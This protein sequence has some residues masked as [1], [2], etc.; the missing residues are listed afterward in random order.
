MDDDDAPGVPVAVLARSSAGPRRGLAK[1]TWTGWENVGKHKADVYAARA[2]RMFKMLQLDVVTRWGS[3]LIM[4]TSF[5]QLAPALFLVMQEQQHLFA[6]YDAPLP[7]EEDF[8]H[9]KAV[10]SVLQP[11]EAAT[12]LLG[13]ESYSTLALVPDTIDQLLYILKQD[14]DD[15]AAYSAPLRKLLRDAYEFKFEP[16]FKEPNLALMAAYTHPQTV[17]RLLTRGYVSGDVITRLEQLMVT[18]MVQLAMPPRVRR[19]GNGTNLRRS[20]I[21]RVL[22]TDDDD[23]SSDDEAE[24]RVVRAKAE[25]E[26]SKFKRAA[27]KCDEAWLVKSKAEFAAS[28]AKHETGASVDFGPYV[29]YVSVGDDDSLSGRTAGPRLSICWR[30]LRN[31]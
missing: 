11:F 12:T 15:N 31:Y 2:S 10:I 3:V 5:F 24:A 6:N 18:E 8:R 17:H 20:S 1:S 16:L 25:R 9:A 19:E 28:S 23:N 30:H 29:W 7:N 13:G 22:Q 27:L 26:L 4:L 14:K 21:E